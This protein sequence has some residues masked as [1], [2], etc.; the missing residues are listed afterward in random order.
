MRIF[1]IALAIL[2]AASRVDCYGN[3]MDDI[4][5]GR[6]APGAGHMSAPGG[7]GP[8]SPFGILFKAEGKKWTKN[9]C[10]TDSDGDGLSNGQELG[11]PECIWVKDGAAP[12]RT[13][14]ITQPGLRDETPEP[15]SAPTLA[16]QLSPASRVCITVYLISA[17]ALAAL[18]F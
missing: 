3:Y 16:V 18:L 5:N 2:V 7:G 4:P 9:L 11:D 8:R 15:T 17:L 6:N 13:T 10:E 1:L 14:G 12:S